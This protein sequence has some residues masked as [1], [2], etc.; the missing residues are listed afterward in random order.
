MDRQSEWIMLVA[1]PQ[2]GSVRAGEGGAPSD[3][4]SPCSRTAGWWR[5]D[6]YVSVFLRGYEDTPDACHT[7]KLQ[8][9]YNIMERFNLT[10]TSSLQFLIKHRNADDMFL[11]IATCIVSQITMSSKFTH[12]TIC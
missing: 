10:R 1:E 6:E 4:C 12:W 8:R 2:G 9:Q 7:T 3:A 11:L 5:A